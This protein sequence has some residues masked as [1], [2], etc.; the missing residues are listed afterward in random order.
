MSATGSSLPAGNGGG[1]AV[2][3]SADIP[4]LDVDPS[5]SNSSPIPIRPMSGCAKPAGGLSRQVERVWCRTLCR[6]ACRAERPPDLLFQPR[7]RMSD[8]ATEKP[9][10]PQS[11]IL[12]AGSAGA[13]QNPCVLNQVL[14]ATAMK[15]LRE[16]FAAAAAPWSTNCW[17]EKA[18]MPSADLAEAFPMSVFPDA[19]GLKQEGR[20]NLLP[21]AGLVFNASAAEPVAAGRIDRSAPH[22]AYVAG[23]MPARRT[24]RLTVL[25]AVSTP[26]R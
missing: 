12:E 14:S 18:S 13:Y 26:R 25:A 4:H 23:P 19:M 20:E 3:G 16:R 10:R 9:W 24:S 22:Q 1:A 6:S 7:R 17:R 2:N 8:F 15:P 11:L 21:Y 5:R